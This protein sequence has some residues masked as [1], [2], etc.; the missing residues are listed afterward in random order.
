MKISFTVILLLI[1]K[2]AFAQQET[3]LITNSK[4]SVIKICA[5]SRINAICKP[6]TVIKYGNKTYQFISDSSNSSFL[7]TFS[8]KDITAIEILKDKTEVA[9]YGDN[10]KNGVIIITVKNAKNTRRKISALKNI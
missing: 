4:D 1:I 6:L 2:F 5:P 10:A 3:N 8:P 9:K 7:N